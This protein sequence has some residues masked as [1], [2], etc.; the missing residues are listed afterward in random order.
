MKT[1]RPIVALS[2]VF[3]T[4]L[5]TTGCQQPATGNGGGSTHDA[6]GASQPAEKVT[7]HIAKIDYTTDLSDG[8]KNTVV[9]T[10]DGQPIT[11]GELLDQVGSELFKHYTDAAN[12]EYSI[13]KNGLETMIEDRLLEK[14]AAK[15]GISKEELL[16]QEVND[17]VGDPT[18]QDLKDFFKENRRRFPPSMTFDQVKSRLQDVWSSRQ[19]AKT[20]AEFIDG[21][22]KKAN[23]E[24]SLPF[25]DLPTIDVSADDDAVRG[26]KN[27][28][29]TIIEFS[30]YQCPY[31]KR[32]S[33][34]MKQIEEEYGDKVAIVFRDFPLQFHKQAQKAAEAAECAGDQGKYWEL[35]DYMFSNQDKLAVDDLKD[36][37]KQLGLD[38]NAF[39]QCLD[40]GAQEAEVQAD[41]RAGEALGIRGTP[42]VFVNGKMINGARP[43]DS[44]K[45]I[46][47]AEL[48]KASEKKPGPAK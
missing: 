35:H 14:E 5:L 7:A 40:S 41:V 32:N 48:A 17:K 23:V 42:I 28:P 9:A 31:C 30:D 19:T 2:V 27:A 44:F 29:V 3:A 10:V 45:Q 4:F 6:A 24:I 39:N 11:M 46:I 47:D 16:K 15:R 1:K 43:F 34:T 8:E 33:E 37:A 18:E 38:S 25:P 21:L 36:A 22:K 13:K 12:K 26:N 20:R